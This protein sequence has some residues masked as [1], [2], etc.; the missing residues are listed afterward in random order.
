MN[1]QVKT[2]LDT[3][4]RIPFGQ[5]QLSEGEAART[6]VFESVVLD[7]RAATQGENSERG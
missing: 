1:R 5:F 2:R 4:A 7:R 3:L 6:L